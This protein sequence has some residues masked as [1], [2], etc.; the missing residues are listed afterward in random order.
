MTRTRI[1]AATGALAFTATVA[2][3]GMDNPMVGGAP[4]Y[5]DKNIIKD[6]AF[7]LEI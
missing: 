3:A 4:M 5:A 2:L 7:Y 6:T 1:F